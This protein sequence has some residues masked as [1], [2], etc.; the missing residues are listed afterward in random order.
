MSALN[1]AVDELAR[2]ESHGTPILSVFLNVSPRPSDRGDVGTRLR[3]LLRPVREHAQVLDHAA[4][5]ALR[6]AID[7][8][9]DLEPRIVAETDGTGIAYFA[10]PD[11]AL[12]RYVPLPRPIW[13]Q[14]VMASRPYLRP[15][16]GALDEFHRVLTVVVEPRRSHLWISWMD[17]IELEETLEGE[18]VRKADYGGWY[19]L[20]EWSARHAADGARHRHY[21]DLAERVA[22]LRRSRHLEVIFVGGRSQSIT[23]FVPFLSR[24][25]RDLVAD[26]FTVD[27]HTL[28]RAQVMEMTR[29]LELAWEERR[30]VGAITA[31]IEAEQAGGLAVTGLADVI[32]AVNIGAVNDLLVANGTVEPGW[33]CLICG[34]VSIEGPTCH[35]CGG[36]SHPEPDVIDRLEARVLA[37]GGTVEH[38]SGPLT[39]VRIGATLRF[40]L[41][42]TASLPA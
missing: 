24:R 37:E 18:I 39:D 25:D 35:R 21:R 3:N 26:T 7:G 34:A 30:K 6:H 22:D 15:L 12:E 16:R 4:T 33:E 8:A 41:P 13:D 38:L 31:L 42:R 14:A 5:T 20:D 23:E 2:V 1:E 32:S 17:E 9:L 10:C 40:R 11:I 36:H 29:R 27:V 28:S 19:G